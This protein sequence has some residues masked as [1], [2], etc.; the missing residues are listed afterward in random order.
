MTTLNDVMSAFRT[1]QGQDLL[2]G[3]TYKIEGHPSF[4]PGT[5]LADLGKYIEGLD[6]D[7]N[8]NLTPKE[9]AQIIAEALVGPDGKPVLG[10]NASAPVGEMLRDVL[11]GG[12][13]GNNLVIADHAEINEQQREIR[14]EQRAQ[15]RRDL[16]RSAA[17]PPP[18]TKVSSQNFENDLRR[19][20]VE[21]RGIDKEA[22]TEL[23]DRVGRL[24]QDGFTRGQIENFFNETRFSDAG[25]YALNSRQDEI[26]SALKSTGRFPEFSGSSMNSAYR[27]KGEPPA[28]FEALEKVTEGGGVFRKILGRLGIAGAAIAAVVTG[29]TAYSDGASAA[30]ATGEGVSAGSDIGRVAVSALRGNFQAASSQA[31]DATLTNGAALGAG[32]LTVAVGGS[33]AAALAVPAV[34]T[35]TVSTGIEEYRRGGLTGEQARQMQDKLVADAVEHGQ[36]PDTVTYSGKEISIAEAL[37]DPHARRDLA[38]MAARNNDEQTVKLIADYGILEAVSNHDPAKQPEAVMAA[39][40]PAP[41]QAQANMRPAGMG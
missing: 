21:A 16:E 24:K 36:L 10:I 27:L 29:A 6:I 34:L 40:G 23:A 38:K 8:K 2:R 15:A 31:V 35:Y 30:E 22:L 20:A 1:G 19:M 39:A 5:M 7:P 28:S 33:T 41:V 3:T 26:F 4:A 11:A 13:L 18:E 12:T 14:T 9:A 37:G 17:P 25:R 32:A